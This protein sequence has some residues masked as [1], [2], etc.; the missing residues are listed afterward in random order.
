LAVLDYLRKE[1]LPSRAARLGSRLGAG[2]EDISR[3]R[4]GLLGVRGRGLMWGLDIV[5]ARGNPDPARTDRI[6]EKAK[7]RGLLVG[8]NG[9]E[10][11]VLALQ[12]PLVITDDDIDFM[13]DILD[14]SCR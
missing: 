2:L 13:L 3:R 6:L 4:P 7:D 1:K 8:K 10:R 5:D 12:P 9:P 11:N 14:T